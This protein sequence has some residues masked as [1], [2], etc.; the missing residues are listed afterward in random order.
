MR[1]LSVLLVLAAPSVASSQEVATPL[2]CTT[3][4][5]PSDSSPGRFVNVAEG[6]NG[7]LAWNDG[8][9]GQFLL[10]DSRG[11]VRAVG[12]RGEGPG[13]FDFPGL[14]SWL[15][16]TIV[17]SDFRLRRVQFFSD[18][19]RLIRVLAG[20]VPTYWT[21]QPDGRIAGLRPTALASELPLPM[22][23]VSQRPGAIA[24]DTVA[25]FANPVVERFER[26]VGRQTVRNRQ[27][28]HPG[29][30]TG[31]SQNGARYCGTVQLRDDAIRLRCT[32]GAGRTIVERTVTLTPRPLTSAIYDSAVALFTRGGNSASDIRS[33][34]KR[35]RFLPL[36]QSLRVDDG[37]AVW[38]QRTRDSEPDAVWTRLHPDGRVRDE[39]VIPKRFRLVRPDGDVVWIAL[40]DN[41]GLET[42]HRCR[43]GS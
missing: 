40:A 16:D 34:I 33:R 10:R 26:V 37:G 14:M 25:S 41:D 13:E 32:D 21:A 42:L 24:M 11:V 1:T 39:V 4:V 20:L 36:V 35:T 3:V 12:R 30:E 9:P 8:R 27:P 6:S 2:S 28:F 29:G 23:L 18:T 17:V 43:I 31:S 7:R 38:I 19:G 5:V 15:G 22:V